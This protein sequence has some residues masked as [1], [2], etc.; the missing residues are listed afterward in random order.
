MVSSAY[1]PRSESSSGKGQAATRSE[2]STVRFFAE[3]NTSEE[4]SAIVL[5]KRSNPRG[6]QGLVRGEGG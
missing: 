4:R 1:W 6:T 5:H 3:A 2:Q